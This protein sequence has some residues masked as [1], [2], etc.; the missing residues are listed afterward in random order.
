MPLNVAV[1]YFSKTKN[2]TDRDLVDEEINAITQ[3]KN[4][5]DSLKNAHQNLVLQQNEEYQS[6]SAKVDQLESLEEQINELSETDN[7]DGMADLIAL[8]CTLLGVETDAES[9]IPDPNAL[10]DDQTALE[11]INY[12][13]E[14]LGDNSDDATD[15]LSSI[16]SH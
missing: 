7:E 5:L 16:N 10:L 4:E 15:L 11:L 1:D 2:E 3:K 6:L 13:A 8:Y 12:C 14:L 9:I